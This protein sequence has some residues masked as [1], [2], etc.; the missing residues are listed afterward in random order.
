MARKSINLALQGGGSHG[1]FTWGVLDRL[2]EDDRVEIAGVSGASA[3]AMNAVVA[4][5]GLRKG[6]A[7]GARAAL[8]AFW[9][10]VSAAARASPI[11]RSPLEVLLGDY[12]LDRN[13]SYLLFDLLTRV[14]SPYDLNPGGVN[15]LRQVIEEAVDFEAVRACDLLA[16]HVSA[17]DVE[18]GRGRVF[19]REQITA[20][21]VLAS[22][23]LP[24]LFPAVEIEGRHYWD[25]G[26]MGNP[27]LYPL[28]EGSASDDIVIV[29]INPVV[30][31][32]VPKTAREI[33][34]RVNEITFNGNLLK[35]LRAIDFVQ[36]LHEQ[37]R[38]EGTR[39]RTVRMHMIE[40]R[41][42]LRRLGASSKINAEQRFLLHLKAIGRAAAS[43]WLERDF[44]AVGRRQT[45]DLRR[46]FEGE[47]PPGGGGPPG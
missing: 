30:R 40:D 35:E 23:C 13:P 45:L 3:G 5:E 38:L 18:T 29:Q 43:R 6:G 1:A 15:P 25:G 2:F 28:F 11:Q 36:R 20:E 44:E 9:T 21:V 8:E 4:A 7:E 47:H 19:H 33:Q 26:Y 27:A 39:Y 46:M 24:T 31:P 12:S 10:R 17:T 41:K 14:A 16:L 42:R 34:D 37:G 22:A 32:G